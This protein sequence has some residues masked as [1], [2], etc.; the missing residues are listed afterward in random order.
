MT[1]RTFPNAT[2]IV[3]VF[4]GKIAYVVC[5]APINEIMLSKGK[6]K[7]NSFRPYL[8]IFTLGK[9]VLCRERTK[10]VTPWIKVSRHTKM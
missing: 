1:I 3:V 6:R 7:I 5:V 2:G 10:N 4:H 8:G 9:N